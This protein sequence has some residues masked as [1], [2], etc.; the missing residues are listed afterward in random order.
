MRVQLSSSCK[1]ACVRPVGIT[2]IQGLSSRL[3]LWY[4]T[5]SS[6]S[7]LSHGHAGGSALLR[8][9]TGC[10][11]TGDRCTDAVGCMMAAG[12]K[13][14]LLDEDEEQLTHL[15]RSL[16]D[17]DFKAVRLSQSRTSISDRAG[18]SD[19]SRADS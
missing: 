13:F 16:A 4:A 5:R 11:H 6:K 19:S 15:G 14:A 7:L 18:H 8:G 2:Q 10:L 17:D 3:V 9:K 1:P 12:D